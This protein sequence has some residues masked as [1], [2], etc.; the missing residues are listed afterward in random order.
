MFVKSLFTPHVGLMIDC[1]HT[2]FGEESTDGYYFGR[3]G[4]TR[5]TR[6]HTADWYVQSSKSECCIVSTDIQYRRKQA[7]DHLDLVQLRRL[8]QALGHQHRQ[9][10]DQH[11]Q[12]AHQDSKYL[13]NL[14]PLHPGSHKGERRDKSGMEKLL[15]ESLIS[16]LRSKKS[17]RSI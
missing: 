15:L 9:Q 14:P 11:R 6:W 16:S 17:Q 3:M 2:C 13:N 5:R 10:G 12:Q 4:F 1:W 7:K 8:D